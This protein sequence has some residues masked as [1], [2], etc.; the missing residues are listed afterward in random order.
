MILCIDLDDT[1]SYTADTI[2]E[3]AIEFDKKY[4]NGTGKVNSVND[5][6]DYFYFARMLNWNREQLIQF[7]D[8]CY[9]DYLQKIKADPLAKEI[10]KKIK[11]MNVNIYIVTSRRNTTNKAIEYTKKWLRNNGIMYDKLFMNVIDKGSFIE[12]IKPDYFIDDSVKNCRD[13]LKKSL[14]TKVFLMNTKFNKNI[15]TTIKR[16]NTLNDLYNEI[17]GDIDNE[18]IRN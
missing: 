3:Y 13:V 14:T 12:K 9:P 10:T 4:L 8:K 2:V 6:E 16:I 15:N 7:F 17:K 11:Q 5:S 1:L 18:R